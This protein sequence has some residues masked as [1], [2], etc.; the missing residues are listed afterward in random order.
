MRGETIALDDVIAPLTRERF[1]AEF[2]TKS[3]LVLNGAKGRFTSLLPWDELNDILEWHQ[4]SPS[5]IKLFKDGQAIDPRLYIDG[6]GGG[7][8]L[9]AG[10]L[11]A[12]LSQGASLVMDDMQELAP[13]VRALAGAFQDVFEAPVMVNLY[14]GWGR[15]KAF[16]LHW[17]A[18]EVFI[19]QLSGRKHWKIFAP[20]RFQPLRDDP[21]QPPEPTGLPEWEGILEDGDMLYMPRGWWHVATPLDEPS[22]HLNF[23]LELPNGADF[24]R[25]WLPRLLRH[26]DLRQNLPRGCSATVR[27][28]YFASLLETL[29]AD[30]RGRDRPG[31]FLR[32]WNA[33]RRAR[34]QVRLP[35][36]P[37]AQKT[38]LGMA[39]P[40]RLA[41]RDGLFIEC[42][43]GERTA[44]FQ[45]AGRQYNVAPQIVPALERLSGRQS[46][47]VRELCAGIGDQ[48]VV[49]AVIATLDMLAGDGVILKDAPLAS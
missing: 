8:R 27:Q 15:Q 17:D 21:D 19:L 35:F 24:L 1:F 49:A 48:Q 12:S 13:R 3:H 7:A 4:P 42:E 14:A 46:L 23:A 41:Q 44:K 45:A 10:C 25:W 43:P 34:P 16:A 26:A 6:E 20:T 40:V 31:E 9:N 33:Y 2:W 38:P 39:T 11:I 5:T 22:L 29:S 37:G 30:G 18:Q 47:M 32:E 28:D 36:A